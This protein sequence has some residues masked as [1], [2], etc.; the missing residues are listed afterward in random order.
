MNVSTDFAAGWTELSLPGPDVE[1]YFRAWA[2]NRSVV[3]SD[4]EVLWES[5]DLDSWTVHEFPVTEV[6]WPV[7]TGRVEGALVAVA[8]DGR[9]EILDGSRPEECDA[10]P[11]T[12]RDGVWLD[13]TLHV[14][15]Q[16]TTAAL[17]SSSDACRWRSIDLPDMDRPSLDI[18][19]GSVVVT[20]SLFTEEP[21]PVSYRLVADGW[22]EPI[23]GNVL[24]PFRA[25]IP[26]REFDPFLEV[27]T[28]GDRTVVASATTPPGL[29]IATEDGTTQVATLSGILLDLDD[30]AYFADQLVLVGRRNAASGFVIAGPIP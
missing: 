12:V 2:T 6:N 4:Y 15:T 21:D 19:E 28:A 18:V 13:S 29:L 11:P 14:L 24:E 1:E 8:S 25:R 10:L 9:V 16:D 20:P 3:V 23:A 27:I 22:S 30:V 26:G 7:W 5:T 17:W